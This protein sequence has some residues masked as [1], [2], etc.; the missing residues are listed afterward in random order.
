M[1]P[2]P[3]ERGAVPG[4]G[5]AQWR[6]D[7][8]R[9]LLAAIVLAAAALRLPGLATV[10]PGLNQDEAANAWNA[11]CLL[12]TGQDQ[13]GVRWP[14]FYVHALGENRTTLYMYLTIPFQAL[15]GL[16]IWTTRLP[17]AVAGVMT[18]VLTYWI[19]SRLFNPSVGLLAAG[20]LSLNPW[21][22][23]LSRFGHEASVGPFLVAVSLAALIWA[24][25]P[26]AS[27]STRPRPWKALV[28]GLTIGVCCYGY[29]A[30]RL[31]I[32]AFFAAS[33]LV[34]CRAWWDL[35]HSGAGQWSVVAL[36]VGLGLTFGPLAYQHVVQP[37]RISKRGDAVRLWDP[38]DPWGRRASMVATRYA[39]HFGPD[40][41]F[42]H[43]DHHEIQWTRGFGVF[44]WYT[45]PLMALGLG[46][47][48]RRMPR[49]H[50]ARILVA[51]LLLYPLGDSLHRGSFYQAQDGTRGMSMHALRS[52]PGLGA[53]IVLAAV[54]GAAVHQWLSRHRRIALPACAAF[55]A[56]VVLL[57][58]RFLSYYFR[59]HPNRPDVQRSFQPDL[60]QASLWLRPRLEAADAVL[61]TTARMNMPYVVMLVTVG[62]DARQWFRDERVVREVGGWDRYYRI[63]KLHF[64]YPGFAPSVVSGLRENGRPDRVL[65]LLRPEEH[66]S[67]SAIHT[68]HGPDGRPNLLIYDTTF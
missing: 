57:D 17:A 9:L 64:L 11:W 34:T 45:L 1:R 37:E 51:W 22:I 7:V 23:Q 33:T 15:G 50:G 10:P 48:L 62:Y 40:F 29:P 26:L 58:T 46:I 38:A 61:V 30:A 54:G 13:V 41:L 60:V 28:A 47:A 59:E 42:S 52:A 4:N 67:A 49:V 18:V 3:G 27:S 6:G 44:Q 31:F 55:A 16:N 56:C 8:R 24:G 5:F 39:A 32:P 25:F 21:H 53:P 36:L 12:R 14:I 2:R 65:L 68:I 43:G 19:A 35:R 66:L 63:G 20:L